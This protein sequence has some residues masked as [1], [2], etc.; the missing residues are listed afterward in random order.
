MLSTNDKC[1]CMVRNVEIGKLRGTNLVDLPGIFQTPLS[2][3]ASVRTEIYGL[4]D[5]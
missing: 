5:D 1:L 4:L 3:A 2:G